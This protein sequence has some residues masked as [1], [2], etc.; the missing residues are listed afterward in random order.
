[1]NKLN[2]YQN[3]KIDYQIRTCQISFLTK[4]SKYPIYLLQAYIRI[5]G[6]AHIDHC[7][8][9]GK[10]LKSSPFPYLLRSYR[11]LR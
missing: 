2:K 11:A 4:A 9:S 7:C 10:T 3:N 6:W 8:Q 1:M 5:S